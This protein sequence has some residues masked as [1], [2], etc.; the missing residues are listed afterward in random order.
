MK[1]HALCCCFLFLVGRSVLDACIRGVAHAMR[2]E[3]VRAAEVQALLASLVSRVVR[4]V[5]HVDAYTIALW[6]D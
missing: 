4:K 6:P 1:H 3:A 5:G 2:E